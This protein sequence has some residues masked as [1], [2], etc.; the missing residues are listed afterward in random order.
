MCLYISYIYWERVISFKSC[1]VFYSLQVTDVN[2]KH[3]YSSYYLIIKGK[4]ELRI[5]T[6]VT[7]AIMDFWFFFSYGMTVWPSISKKYNIILWTSFFLQIFDFKIWKIKTTSL[8]IYWDNYFLQKFSPS[9]A[10]FNVDWLANYTK[11]MLG[12]NYWPIT[13][14]DSMV[15]ERLNYQEIKRWKFVFSRH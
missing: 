10:L 3:F 12:S 7:T 2:T 14:G 15:W 11:T 4:P 5:N 6:M 9:P 8:K 1:Q 13:R